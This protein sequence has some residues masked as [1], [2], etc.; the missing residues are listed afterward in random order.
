MQQGPGSIDVLLELRH[1]LANNLQTIASVISLQASRVS[2]LQTGDA[3]RTALNRVRAITGAL[4]RYTTADLTTLHIGDYLPTLVR[5]LTSE[6]GAPD[7]VTV[8]VASTDIAVSVEQGIALA[9]IA[10]ELTA[11][12]LKHAF[13]GRISGRI[14]VALIY[15]GDAT[16]HAELEVRDDGGPM[17]AGWS[18]E[19]ADSTGFV[20]VRALAS[21]LSGVISLQENARGKAFRLRFPLSLS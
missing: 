16:E 7:C 9:L 2:D 3:L 1:R 21:Q 14:H 20:L 13:P 11:N 18:L 17:P 12:A 8:E 15:S 4:G 5:E 19:T 10:N 6:C